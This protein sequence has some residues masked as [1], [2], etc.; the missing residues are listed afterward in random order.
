M[1]APPRSSSPLFDK[2]V[3]S[4]GHRSEGEHPKQARYV[5]GHQR[6]PPARR[7]TWDQGNR[8]AQCWGTIPH[9]LEDPLSVNQQIDSGGRTSNLLASPW[10]SVQIPRQLLLQTQKFSMP[11]V[12]RVEVRP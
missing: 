11:C 12:M 10:L 2:P 6:G 8:L 9:G 5:A 7:L 3:G 4:I 1:D